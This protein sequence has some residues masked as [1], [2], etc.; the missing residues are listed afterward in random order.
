M[1]SSQ[2]TAAL[3]ATRA[4]EHARQ[5]FEVIGE[6]QEVPRFSEILGD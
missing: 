1:A 3:V 5:D 6:P 2:G 4:R